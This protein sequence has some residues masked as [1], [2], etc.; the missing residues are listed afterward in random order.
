MKAEDVCTNDLIP[1][2]NDFDKPKVKADAEGVKLS[3]GF[4]A[5][6]VEEIKAHLFDS[7][8]K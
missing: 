2:A 5:L 6:D 1:A 3:E 4:A 8:V 7:A